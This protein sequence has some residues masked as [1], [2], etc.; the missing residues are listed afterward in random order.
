MGFQPP[1]DG[2]VFRWARAGAS[3][4]DEA[5]L[6]TRTLRSA[7]AHHAGVPRRAFRELLRGRR[8][9]RRRDALLH[10]A[11]LD[12]RRHGRHLPPGHPDGDELCFPAARDGRARFRRAEPPGWTRDADADARVHRD[13]GLLRL[14]ARHYAAQRGGKAAGA[15][16]GRPLQAPASDAPARHVHAAAH[17]V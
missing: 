12:E 3:G 4:R 14:R 5:P 7:R 8:T 6:R 17:A 13:D 2:G 1:S 15:R 16:A 10:A 9:L 11:D